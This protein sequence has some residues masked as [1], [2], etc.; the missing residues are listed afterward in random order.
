MPDCPNKDDK[1]HCDCPDGSCPPLF[2]DQPPA[3]ASPPDLTKGFWIWTK[4]VVAGGGVVPGCARP[5]RKVVPGVDCPVNRLTIDITCDNMYTLYVNGKLVGSGIEFTTPQRYTVKFEDTNKVVVAVY[6][7]QDPVSLAQ[8]GLIC[9]GVV[10]NSQE[11]SPKETPFIT[12]GTWKTFEGDNFDRNFIKEDF[13]DQSWKDAVVE[14]PYLTGPWAGK[15]APPT[16]TDQNPGL[17]NIRPGAIPKVPDA[18]DA[19]PADV[20]TSNAAK[21]ASANN[22]AKPASVQNAAKPTL[23]QNIAKPASAQSFKSTPG[24]R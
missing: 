5:F 6:A 23:I 19:K 24:F 22:A 2:P 8:V 16:E 20:I 4:E 11:K 1:H 12:D 3:T 15:V 13:N 21:L 17:K 10:W 14:G 9:S 18:P 7:V